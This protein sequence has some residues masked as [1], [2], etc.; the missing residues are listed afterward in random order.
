MAE[1]E[2]KKEPLDYHISTR[3]TP[4]VAQTFLL[5]EAGKRPACAK[6]VV[7]YQTGVEMR[8][9]R[10]FPVSEVNIW[11]LKH[12][13]E[14]AEPWFYERMSAD[15]KSDFMN[16]IVATFGLEFHFVLA[17]CGDGLWELKP[18]D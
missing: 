16:E 12:G 1:T 18:A 5:F 9:G 8:D 15:E 3:S 13:K 6:G 14:D 4:G 2:A 17:E 7:L 11:P 10:A